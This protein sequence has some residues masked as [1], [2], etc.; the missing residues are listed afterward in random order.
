MFNQFQNNNTNYRVFQFLMKKSNKSKL[1]QKKIFTLSR[2]RILFLK[3]HNLQNL[4]FTNEK[5]INKILIRLKSKNT[6]ILTQLE[7][8]QSNLIQSNKSINFE[9]LNQ[10]LKL[11][12]AKNYQEAIKI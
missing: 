8:S 2:S 7:L 10:L 11:F 3:S 4:K 12:K 6:L 9:H 5:L 1:W